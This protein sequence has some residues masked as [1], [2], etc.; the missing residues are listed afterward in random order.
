M[1][2]F[3]LQTTISLCSS[4]SS[5]Q[6]KQKSQQME[7]ELGY[8]VTKILDDFAYAEFLIAKDRT[9]PLFISKETG[10][11]FILTAHLKGCHSHICFF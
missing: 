8:K 1:H 7:L 10:I 2:V 11:M 5:I 4:T 9:G 6:I 3:P